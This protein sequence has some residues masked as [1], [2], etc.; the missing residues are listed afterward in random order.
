MYD[1]YHY[2]AG[3]D[4]E[5]A[6]WN[7]VDIPEKEFDVC[8]SQSLSKSTSIYTQDYQPEY[9]EET[10]HT[11]ADTT[12][13]DWKKAYQNVAMTP[14][15]IINAAGKLAKAFLE[16][17]KTRVEGIYLKSLVEECKDWSNDEL[18]VIEE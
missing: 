16:E 2:P 8:V 4:N 5:Q 7:Q 3:T 12:N 18:E 13:T 11:D 15:D 1:N 10:G 14:L 9:D 6:P 17:G